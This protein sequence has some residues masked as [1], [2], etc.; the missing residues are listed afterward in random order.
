MTNLGKK[1]KIVP[2]MTDRFSD[3]FF[4]FEIALR[5][6]DDIQSGIEGRA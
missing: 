6:V 3:Q 2:A 1:K 4:A 5:G